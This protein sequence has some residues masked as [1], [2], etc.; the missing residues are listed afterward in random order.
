MLYSRTFFAMGFANFL[1]LSSFSTFFLFP[2]YILKHGGNDVDIGVIMGSFTLA[3]V[4][5]RPWI[6]EMI[7]RLGRKKSYTLGC[8]TM[9][10]LPM[11]YLPFGGNLNDFYLPILGVRIVHG[12]GFAICLTAAFT[13]MADL[14][15]AGRLNEGLGIFGVSGLIGAAVGPSVAELVIDRFGFDTLFLVAGSMATLALLV[16]L[17]LSETLVH[18]LPQQRSFFEVFRNRKVS[19]VAML[20]VL[21]GF[22]LAASNGFVSPYASERQLAFVSWYYIAYSTSAVL[23]RV[24]GAKL[25]DRLGEERVLPYAMILTGLGLSCLVLPGGSFILVVAG[26][27]G[28]CGHGFLYPSLN[29][30]A[31][32]NEPTAIRGKITGAF[33]GSIDAGAFIGSITLGFI[34]Q[35]A[36]FQTLF[37]AAGGALLAAFLLYRRSRLLL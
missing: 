1:I 3:S 33:T 22:G 26:S 23:T 9:S 2:L 10:V 19:L 17:P 29:A 21:F 27:L 18:G 37:L 14:I 7:D 4:V 31:L 30:L 32:R 15:P 36:G 11:T 13:Y 24:L 20:A 16:H 6:S 5:C 34:G 12:M 35:W 28:G 25:A 8:L